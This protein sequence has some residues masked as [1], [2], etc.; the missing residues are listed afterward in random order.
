MCYNIR[1]ATIPEH[2]KPIEGETSQQYL[3]RLIQSGNVTYT[4]VD[5][6]KWKEGYIAGL[7][8]TTPQESK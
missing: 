3:E 1:M 2:I 7:Q 4:E 6:S 8:K 5:N